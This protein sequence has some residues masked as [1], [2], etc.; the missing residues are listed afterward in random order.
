M[1][2]KSTIAIVLIYTMLA[3]SCGQLGLG[4]KSSKKSSPKK[5]YSVDYLN[6]DQVMQRLRGL[7]AASLS[8]QNTVERSW[9]W[10]NL[11]SHI[12]QLSSVQRDE[13][14][15]YLTRSEDAESSEQFLLAYESLKTPESED[16]LFELPPHHSVRIPVTTFC[17][18][19][20]KST[21]PGSLRYE[22]TPLEDE[23]LSRQIVFKYLESREDDGDFQ[24]LMWELEDSSRQIVTLYQFGDIL[25]ELG[26]EYDEDWTLEEFE[27]ASSTQ[28][29]ASELGLKES[30]FPDDLKVS[31]ISTKDYSAG[32]L[33][34]FNESSET[35]HKITPDMLKV[36]M[37]PSSTFSSSG[38]GSEQRDLE[39]EYQSIYVSGADPS[40]ADTFDQNASEQAARLNE[41]SRRIDNLIS[42]NAIESEATDL[43]QANSRVVA[44]L[45]AQGE[46]ESANRIQRQLDSALYTLESGAD[47]ASAL[48]P[49]VNDLRD[50]Y[51]VSTGKDLITGETL[52]GWERVL[53][54]AGIIAGS[55][56]AFRKGIDA[57]ARALGLSEGV[58]RG[59]RE[60]L[61]SAKK[62][63]VG[64]KIGNTLKSAI[65]PAKPGSDLTKLGHAYEK[66]GSRH[67]DRWGR[68]SGSNAAKNEVGVKHLNDV[69]DGPGKFE[70]ITTQQGIIFLEKRLPDGRGVRLNQ[71][72]TFKG[73]LDPQ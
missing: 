14:D 55:G 36:R 16:F 41:L 9:L 31:L 48:T 37:K 38:G 26:F 39:K 69:L 19:R 46:F 27:K 54:A 56:A 35:S 50:I 6:F 3:S 22:K 63:G 65:E 33:I 5:E 32:E 59:G 10:Q 21:P 40:A 15:R 20:L 58:Y 62:S 61:E 73:F 45:M 57:L 49:G 44:E 43:L 7:D 70:E 2:R 11:F 51:E 72:G 53:A 68:V 13:L 60:V 1:F 64:G 67:P 8:M 18:H 4:G 29:R 52:E 28:S 25:G 23:K 34:F 12:P 66:H 24:G 42:A 47:L 30:N 71:D 17:L